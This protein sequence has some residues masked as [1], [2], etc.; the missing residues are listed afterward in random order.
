MNLSILELVAYCLASAVFSVLGTLLLLAYVVC[1]PPKPRSDAPLASWSLTDAG[2]LKRTLRNDDAAV[3]SIRG[4]DHRSKL[5]PE[6]ASIT[7][8]TQ[9][10]IGFPY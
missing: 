4:T 5:P 6:R 2:E 8:I 10:N 9:D 3:P 7:Q 1:R